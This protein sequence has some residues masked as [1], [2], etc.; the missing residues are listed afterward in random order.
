MALITY[1]IPKGGKI[2]NC[3]KRLLKLKSGEYKT[4][5]EQQQKALEGAKG[6]TKAAAKGKAES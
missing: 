6:V 5:D 1:S 3:G 4:S 2:I